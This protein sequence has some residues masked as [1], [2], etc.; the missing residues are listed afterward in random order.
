MNRE[1]LF[2]LAK[3][4]VLRKLAGP[5]N[6]RLMDVLQTGLSRGLIGGGLGALEGGLRGA[7]RGVSQG[8]GFLGRLGGLL[9]GGAKGALGGGA[10][11]GLGAG[12][13]GLVEGATNRGPQMRRNLE[14]AEQRLGPGGAGKL[15]PAS[16]R[17]LAAADR[18]PARMAGKLAPILG[19]RVGLEKGLDAMVPGKAKAGPHA[20]MAGLG[21]LGALSLMGSNN[22][23]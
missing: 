5:E 18:E 16:E 15:S 14:W 4:A 20:A 10:G 11:G 13:G 21:G 17:R 7:G 8:E 12:L 22:E 6:H 1:L 19:H 3:V 23:S 9:S 2:T